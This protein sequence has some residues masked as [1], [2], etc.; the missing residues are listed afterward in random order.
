MWNALATMVLVASFLIVIQVS[1]GSASTIAQKTT[2]FLSSTAGTFS[3]FAKSS[4]TVY[5]TSS[6]QSIGPNEILL[7]RRHGIRHLH[8]KLG[9]SSL[10]SV[11]PHRSNGESH[12]E[13]DRGT[14]GLKKGFGSSSSPSNVSKNNKNSI[15]TPKSANNPKDIDDESTVIR[16]TKTYGSA[17]GSTPYSGVSST[18]TSNSHAQIHLYEEDDLTRMN[19]FFKSNIAWHPLFRSV[20]VNDSSL[21][22]AWHLLTGSSEQMMEELLFDDSNYPWRNLPHLPSGTE[23]M[24]KLSAFLDASQKA[25]VDIPITAGGEKEDDAND[26]HFIEEGRRYEPLMG[27]ILLSPSSPN[28]RHYFLSSNF[29]DLC[30]IRHLRLLVLNRFHV[31]T[32]EPAGDIMTAQQQSKALDDLLFQTCWSEI[33]ALRS[34]GDADSGSLILCPDVEIG[35]L[36]AFLDVNVLRPLS[37]LGIE[38]CFEVTS[39][40]RGS[41]AIRMIHK[42]SSIPELNGR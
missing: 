12:S 30:Y 17:F 13:N 31:L 34:A 10:W 39:Y 11:P 20:A 2:C 3:T 9:T 27:V 24:A 28:C 8:M 40:Q 19:Q 32:M 35:K 15:S 38:D 18:T 29:I 7:R 4:A 23:N 26:L 33:Q 41:P 6:S 5:S 37:W 14:S 42:L 21:I 25:L 16:V 36:R 1:L 22:P